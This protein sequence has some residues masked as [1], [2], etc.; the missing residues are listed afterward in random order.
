MQK[1]MIRLG[2]RGHDL[3]G[4]TLEE[5]GDTL[6]KYPQLR[7]IQCAPMKSFPNI[8]TSSDKLS[9]GL[10]LHV[11][12]SLKKHN[13]SISI[14]GCYVNI[15]QFEEKPELKKTFFD[16]MIY[17][18]AFGSEVIATET[19]SVGKGYTT[20]NF[21]EEAFQKAL[22][23]IRGMA[24]QAEKTGV[25]LGIE[26]GINHPLCSID[27]AKRMLEEIPINNLRILLDIANLITPDNINHQDELIEEA[28]DKL[29]PWICHCHLKD[30]VMGEDGK[31][32]AVAFGTGQL[33]IEKYLSEIQKHKPY[34]NC[35]F[36]AT[37]ED[38]MEQAIHIVQ[39]LM[40]E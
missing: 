24:E 13:V 1:T 27:K 20:D 32:K 8:F 9:P 2:V 16:Y 22:R 21:T 10:A 4:N 40:T 7:H 14:L 30:F 25:I 28:F 19:G 17:T 18:K 31:I 26:P 34:C 38:G 3:P 36:E 11:C 12:E 39:S 37:K 35:T 33:H 29:G 5:F 6:S 15:M 23:I